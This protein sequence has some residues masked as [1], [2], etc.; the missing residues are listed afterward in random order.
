[1]VAQF[2]KRLNSWAG[3]TLGSSTRLNPW[4]SLYVNGCGQTIHN[5]ASAGQMG[6]VYSLTKWDERNFL[7]GET[8][9]FRPEHYW[10]SA[11]F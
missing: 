6:F 8:L 5:D 10:E 3:A 9:L 11:R 1:L 4:L 2:V 7:G